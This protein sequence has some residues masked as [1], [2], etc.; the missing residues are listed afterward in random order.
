MNAETFDSIKTCSKMLM[1]GNQ[2]VTS[3]AV[4]HFLKAKN[5]TPDLVLT[6]YDF[7]HKISQLIEDATNIKRNRF[8]VIEVSTEEVSKNRMFVE[9]IYN[10]RN[11]G[12][13]IIVILSNHFFIDPGLRG[14]F[15]YIWLF[16]THYKSTQRVFYNH[17]AN[18]NDTFED[19]RRVF[20]DMAGDN[21][22]LIIDAIATPHK[23]LWYQDE[24]C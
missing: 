15:D 17:Y 13:G 16:G 18:F 3:N 9:L 1:I 14:S 2:K 19:F 12:I 24:L 22:A 21:S 8:V 6:D 23:I 5:I 10:G 4:K 11:Y 20:V 7:V